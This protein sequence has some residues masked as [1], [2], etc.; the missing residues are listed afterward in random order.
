MSSIVSDN[1]SEN[2]GWFIDTEHLTHES[3]N[4]TKHLNK[5][6]GI[7][8]TKLSVIQED[9]CEYYSNNQDCLDDMIIIE[10][11]EFQNDKKQTII[12]CILSYINVCI[13]N[14]FDKLI[15]AN[16]KY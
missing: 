12:L 14:A 8:N 3:T 1:L 7:Q 4:F 6:Y 10:N 5:K 15:L 11:D 2:W 9:E 13:Y 16:I